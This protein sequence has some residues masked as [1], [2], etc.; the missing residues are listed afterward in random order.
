MQQGLDSKSRPS[1]K[2]SCKFRFRVVCNLVEL[3][4]NAGG[5]NSQKDKIYPNNP[6]IRAL[7]SNRINILN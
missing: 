5:Y 3:L 1:M 4:E 7:S 2:I 6:I